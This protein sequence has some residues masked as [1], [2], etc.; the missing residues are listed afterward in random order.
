MFGTSRAK[1]I[2]MALLAGAFVVSAVAAGLLM[3]MGSTPAYYNQL[4][5]LST[6]ELS[7]ASK[8]FVRRSAGIWNL[9]ATETVWDGAFNEQQV[10][11]WLA[12]DFVDKQIAV[13]PAGV[14]APRVAFRRGQLSL[15]FTK[16]LYVMD[17]VIS[18]TARVWLPEPNLVAVEIAEVRAGAIPLPSGPVVRTISSAAASAGVELVWQQ[19]DGKPVA[20]LRLKGPDNHNGF[21]IEHIELNDGSLYVAG[22]S[23]ERSGRR[24]S[25]PQVTEPADVSRNDQSA[26]LMRR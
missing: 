5:R 15:A 14:S 13:L 8:Q 17:V 1:R 24:P 3:C 12:C 7:V 19:N 10:N 26:S 4:D 23:F 11:A 9:M 20:L 16:D 25:K 2:V 22:R 18:G 6:E 21:G